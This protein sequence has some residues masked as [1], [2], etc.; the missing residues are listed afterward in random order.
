MP[1]G[2][3]SDAGPRLDRGDFKRKGRGEG[4]DRE[5]EN[6]CREGEVPKGLRRRR[7]LMRRRRTAVAY[8]HEVA[9]SSMRTRP[10]LQ[11]N[12]A[13]ASSCQ[14]ALLG[15]ATQLGLPRR[16]RAN[17][18]GL[19]HDRGSRGVVVVVA[20]MLR[21]LGAVLMELGTVMEIFLAERMR[22]EGADL[23]EGR[24]P[25]YEEVPAQEEDEHS[26]MQ[27][28]R[29]PA[30]L[31]TCEVEEIANEL[32]SEL[33]AKYNWTPRKSKHM[34]IV[35][36]AMVRRNIHSLLPSMRQACQGMQKVLDAFAE[37]VMNVPMERDVAAAKWATSF[38]KGVRGKCRSAVARHKRRLKA[39]QRRQALQNQ[40]QRELEEEE[41]MG[42]PDLAPLQDLRQ[43]DDDVE[44]LV[45]G[46][47]ALND[48]VQEDAIEN[49]MM[50]EGERV[51][52][53]DPAGPPGHDERGRLRDEEADEAIF[54]QGRVSWVAMMQ[55]DME[56]HKARGECIG[57]YVAQLQAMLAQEPVG[58]SEALGVVDALLAA[59]QGEEADESRPDK[60]D[61]FARKWMGRLRVLLQQ[62]AATVIDSQNAV[63]DEQAGVLEEVHHEA[64]TR[65]LKRARRAQAEDDRA[66]RE[67]MDENNGAAT[68]STSSRST[69]RTAEVLLRRVLVN[70]L[71]AQ[72]GSVT[73][74]TSSSVEVAVQLD[75]TQY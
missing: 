46:D 69:P 72:P 24:P 39:E 44:M 10:I 47:V 36:G 11:W 3:T 60:A 29:Q 42:E 54:M 13:V 21:V 4:P 5:E 64:T 19:F 2:D 61:E 73:A 16:L 31:K 32:W 17:L 1:P 28:E 75:I 65:R 37:K 9:G 30:Q 67:A 66:L 33:L 23:E 70:G 35:V 55:D 26:L 18:Q 62:P 40:A 71:T 6:A 20:G 48:L 15:D 52:Q 58:D 12:D 25:W 27:R 43:R 41:P 51:L 45:E 63:V 68:S 74:V 49:D 57:A 14:R 59:Y 53:R 34:L 7:R 8:L 50:Q 38:W 56:Y 22:H